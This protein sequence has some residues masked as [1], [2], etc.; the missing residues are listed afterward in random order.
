VDRNVLTMWQPL[1]ELDNSMK[2]KIFS[3]FAGSGFLDLGFESEGFSIA[4]VNEFHP[5]FLDAYKYSR[6]N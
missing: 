2:P 5:P 6:I 3:F 4:H 1:A